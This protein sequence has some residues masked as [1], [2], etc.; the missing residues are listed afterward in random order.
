MSGS[1]QTSDPPDSDAAVVAPP[2]IHAAG[3]WAIVV[4]MAVAVVVLDQISKAWAL[5][6]LSDGSAVDIVWTLRLKLAFNTG[7]AFSRGSGAGPIIG[8]V[9]L[10]IVVVLLVIARKV[11]SRAQLLV[12]GVIIGGALG[13]IIDRLTRV[14]EINPFTGETASGFMSGAVVDFIDVQWWP[15]WNVADMAV[16]CGGIALAVLTARAVPDD[17]A[18]PS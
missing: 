15:V 18:P 6:R 12:I 5:G 10:S 13:N 11:Q 9:A 1:D 8:L 2:T 4:G 14:G 7:M 17:A 3:R 16:V